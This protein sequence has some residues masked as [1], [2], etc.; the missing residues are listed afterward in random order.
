MNGITTNYGIAGGELDA[1]EHLAA[2]IPR[3]LST[4]EAKA[5]LRC[6]FSAAVTLKD[7]REGASSN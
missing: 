3:L 7:K 5:C 6:E 1:S 2:A 4:S